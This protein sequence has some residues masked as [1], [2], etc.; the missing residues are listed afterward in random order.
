MN[1]KHRK[2]LHSLF[3]HPISGNISMKDVG[4]VFAELGAGLN[5]GHGGKLTVKL[6][7]HSASFHDRGHSMGKDEVVEVRKFLQ[8]CGID[9]ARD[10]PL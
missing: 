2:T 4:H 3:S 7:G 1:H 6:K 8:G 10:F 9:P 5:H